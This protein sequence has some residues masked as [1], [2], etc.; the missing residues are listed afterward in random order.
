MGHEIV[1]FRDR[2]LVVHDGDLWGIRHFLV[3]EAIASAQPEIATFVSNWNWI[4]PGVYLGIDLDGF[5]A[6]S[7]SRQQQIVDLLE[8]TKR[9]IA[10]FRTHVAL[11][12]LEVHVNSATSFHVVPQPIEAWIS[13]IDKFVTLIINE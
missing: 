9:R 6:V 10:A 13:V 12:Y 5:I 11:T 1:V 4:G 7:P 8:A 3:A 2:H